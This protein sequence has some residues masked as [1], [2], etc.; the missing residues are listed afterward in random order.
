[1][2][3]GG[4]FYALTPA[5]GRGPGRRPGALGR[6]GRGGPGGDGGDQRRRPPG[7]PGGPAHRRL[8]PRRLPRA[9]PRRRRR[10]RRDVDPSGLAGP[11]ARAARARRRGW[12][13]CTRAASWR[14]ATPFVN[15]SVIGTRFTGRLVEET[16]V[17]GVPAVIPEITGRAWITGMGQYLLDRRG[18]VSGRVRALAIDSIPRTSASSPNSNRASG[19]ALVGQRHGQRDDV[20]E[21]VDGQRREVA[22]QLGDELP[23][24]RRAVLGACRATPRTRSRSRTAAGCRRRRRSPGRGGRRRAARRAWPSTSAARSGRSGCSR[25]RRGRGRGGRPSTRR[26][27]ADRVLELLLPRRRRRA[28]AMRDL[29]GDPVDHQRQQLVLAATRARTATPGRSRAA[30]R[31][32]AC[33]APSTPPSSSTAIAASTIASGSA[34]AARLRRA[35]DARRRGR[36]STGR[37]DTNTILALEHVF[38]M[39]NNVRNQFRTSFRKRP[40]PTTE[41]TRPS[42]PLGD[43]RPDPRRRVHGPAR[44]H[45]RQRRRAVDPREPRRQ[46]CRRCSGSPAATRSRSRSASSPAAGSATSSAAA[47]CSCSASPASPLA[48]ALCGA[49][50]VAR[51]A[52]RAAAC[53]QGAVRRAH[54][55]AGLRDPAAGLPAGR[56]AEG[57]RPVRP[58]DRPSARCSARSSA[59]LLVD[60]DLFGWAGARSSSSTSRSA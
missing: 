1:M 52:D 59:A 48:S 35:A 37:L 31:P 14:S 13:S 39:S 15:E 3:Y 29:A 46:R 6:A 4:N 60:G 58:R 10:R 8:P 40:A 33:S 45:D 42:A 23:R 28:S 2:A 44:R 5:A 30:R 34:R 54:D 11:L 32:R 43:P 57:V 26:I 50:A 51:D 16:T 47:G 17:A 56:A 21:A 22:P 24:P 12:R 18:S 25:A 55:P 49:A 53:V 36:S 9:G 7:P 20:R 41:A 19:S 38:V 27:A